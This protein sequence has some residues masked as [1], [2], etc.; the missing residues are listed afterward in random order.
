MQKSTLH[1]LVEKNISLY[2]FLKE[3][4]NDSN[5][6]EHLI[7]FGAIYKNKKRCLQN[8]DLE[9]GDYIRIHSRPKR[10]FKPENTKIIFED[11]NF[12]CIAKVA[13]SPSHPMLDNYRENCKYVTEQILQQKLWSTNRLDIGTSGLLCFAKHKASANAFNQLLKNKKVCKKYVCL[14]PQFLDSGHYIHYMET[15]LSAPKKIY[16]QPED[17]RLTCE[18]VIESCKKTNVS[19]F[20][21]YKTKI[22]L[23]TGRTHQIRAQLA[24]LGVPILGD[25]LYGSDHSLQDRKWEKF[26][27]S[28]T[29]LTF[30]VFSTKYHWQ[31]PES[32]CFL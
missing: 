28:C 9:I 21:A 16:E 12:V 14:I 7:Q 6:S 13:G 1:F 29:E 18:L 25:Q 26:Y 27:L 10:Y 3:V 22:N 2:D 5:S 31:L 20:E 4:L 11:P 23:V 19:L 24:Y 15:S 30:E 17:T 8:C 32:L